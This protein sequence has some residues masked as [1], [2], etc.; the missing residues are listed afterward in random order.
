MQPRPAPYQ[1]SEIFSVTLPLKT[2]SFFSDTT[3]VGEF[4]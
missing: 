4:F 2:R 1:F 3:R